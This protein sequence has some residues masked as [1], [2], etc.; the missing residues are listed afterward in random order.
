MSVRRWVTQR[1]HMLGNALPEL[2][3]G[4]GWLL[5]L[6]RLTVSEGKWT[7]LCIF[8]KARQTLYVFLAVIW[9][10]FW[11]S[12]WYLVC[13]PLGAV[14]WVQVNVRTHQIS[15]SQSSYLHSNAKHLLCIAAL[16][17]WSLLGL[18]VPL[19]YF[20]SGGAVCSSFASLFLP[21]I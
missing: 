4:N 14:A 6:P 12:N 21:N 13:I 16:Q 20:L 2:C 5:R 10:C 9:Q 1:Y 8:F 19:G 7:R 17:K 3:T 15:Q 11:G 18:W